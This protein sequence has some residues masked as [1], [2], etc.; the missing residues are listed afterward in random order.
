MIV[1]SFLV[2]QISL[3]LAYLLPIKVIILLGSLETP[4]YFPEFMHSFEKNNL[5]LGLAITA[6]MF[7]LINIVCTRFGAYRI[8]QFASDV[9]AGTPDFISTTAQVELTRGALQDFAD[10]L[11][12]WS[13][14]VLALV[15]LMV[16]YPALSAVVV[17][18]IAAAGLTVWLVCRWSARANQYLDEHLDV[19]VQSLF[20][21]GFLACFVFIVADYLIPI[22]PP[23]LLFAIIGLILSRQFFANVV[24]AFNKMGGLL[25]RSGPVSG[26]LSLNHANQSKSQRT[27]DQFWRFLAADSRKRWIDELLIEIQSDIEDPTTSWWQAESPGVVSFT[28]GQAGSIADELLVKV[29]SEPKRHYGERE[30]ILL[31]EY[32]FFSAGPRLLAVTDL[33]GFRCHV[34]EWRQYSQVRNDA[35]KAIRQRLRLDLMAVSPSRRLVESEVRSRANL[36]SRLKKI[37]FDRFRVA[38]S[39]EEEAGQLQ[40]LECRVPWLERSLEHVPLEISKPAFPDSSL[41]I[42]DAEEVVVLDWGD[43]C[44]D[45]IGARWSLN[46]NEIDRLLVCYRELQGVRSDCAD[47]SEDLVLLAQLLFRFEQL[48]RQQKF[49]ESLF[50]VPAILERIR[51]IEMSDAET[52]VQ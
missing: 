46:A 44:V 43:W 9:L 12:R 52:V 6:G 31:R 49:S 18:L 10:S 40:L 41:L 48:Y 3:L 1:C 17:A 50:L 27:E 51:D 8:R 34:F 11:A 29:F 15:G 22:A 21:I 33:A 2:G 38:V 28:V 14:S 16:F 32:P 47:F 30:A 7:Y 24:V 19:V 36:S 4:T 26:V 23:S 25:A 39:S 37:S 20:G 13:F 45:P 5:V 42:N 35:K